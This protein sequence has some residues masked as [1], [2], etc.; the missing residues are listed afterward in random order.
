[1]ENRLHGH[2]QRKVAGSGPCQL[3]DTLLHACAKLQMNA[4]L[5]LLVRC[6]SFCGQL[7]SCID[8]EHESELQKKKK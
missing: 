2:A 6:W 4:V 8:L 7:T 3:V 5:A 1:M